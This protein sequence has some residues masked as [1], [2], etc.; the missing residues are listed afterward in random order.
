MCPLRRIL[1]PLAIACP[2][3]RQCCQDRAIA[4]A[5]WY[6]AEPQTSLEKLQE[7]EQMGG[8][9]RVVE[10]IVGA[11]G[12]GGRRKD[13]G[14]ALFAWSVGVPTDLGRLQEGDGGQ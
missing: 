9:R 5:L 13:L 3:G 10:L 2:H 4:S 11:S 12:D 1:E 8:P 14:M 7:E 6:A